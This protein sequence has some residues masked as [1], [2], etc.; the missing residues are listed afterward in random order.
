[1]LSGAA[2][3]FKYVQ[4]GL[5]LVLVFVGVKMA[6]SDWVKIPLGASLAVIVVLVGGSVV[7]S[8]VS[9]GRQRRRPN[10]VAFRD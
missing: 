5:A 3:R 2:E 1:V 6:I 10:H 8:L 4:P 9:T 7:G